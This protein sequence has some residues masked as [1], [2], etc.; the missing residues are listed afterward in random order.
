MKKLLGVLFATIL[1]IVPSA[2]AKPDAVSA[3]S[4]SVSADSIK[5][6]SAR[7]NWFNDR[8]DYGSR[9]L[10]YNPAPASPTLNCVLKTANASQG[11][12]KITGLVPGTLYN[13]SIKAINTRDNADP[14]YTTSG[15]FT[16]L[17]TLVVALHPRT[18]GLT[19]SRSIAHRY[20]LRGRTARD[21]S[22]APAGKLVQKSTTVNKEAASSQAR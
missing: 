9:T 12:F 11:F 10:C 22:K 3:A 19:P 21:Q 4:I 13:F 7:I 18:A 6:V 16:T 1:L 17:D 2:L 15:S 20:D 8:Y 14:P 5:S